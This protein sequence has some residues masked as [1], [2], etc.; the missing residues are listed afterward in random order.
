MEPQPVTAR[1][2][3]SSTVV[4]MAR[5]DNPRFPRGLGFGDL[6]LT[7]LLVQPKEPLQLVERELPRP[8]PGEVTVTLEA[9]GLGLTDWHVAMLDA[10][11]RAPLVL[12]CEAVGRVERT[13]KRVGITP[14]ATSCGTCEQC[15]VG[16][17]HRCAAA[18]WHGFSRD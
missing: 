9:C 5:G 17:P 2:T 3:A 6:S 12:G 8:G 10:L 7:P 16:T 18:A 1:S 4:R 15:R 14:L 13:G 11:P